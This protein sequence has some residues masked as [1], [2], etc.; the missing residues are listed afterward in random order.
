MASTI[1]FPARRWRRMQMPEM[2]G[3]DSGARLRRLQAD[4]PGRIAC[5]EAELVRIAASA[6]DRQRHRSPRTFDA[7]CC[8]TI[9][10]GSRGVPRDSSHR[11]VRS[12][13]M[14]KRAPAALREASPRGAASEEMALAVPRDEHQAAALDET[15][16]LG[17]EYDQS[18]PGGSRSEV[19]RS[20]LGF[21][22]RNCLLRVAGPCRN[23][24]VRYRSGLDARLG[25]PAIDALLQHRERHRAPAEDACRGTRGCRTGHRARLRPSGAAPG[26]SASRSC[27]WW[28][29]RA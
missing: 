23:W 7:P 4:A 16:T 14:R 22:G 13:S 15:R 5:R 28:P 12:R 27:S 26:S 3:I 1:A 25:H 9:T 17:T 19:R 11:C 2:C 10:C 29:G 6:P 8:E 24:P 21:L 20:Q 18:R